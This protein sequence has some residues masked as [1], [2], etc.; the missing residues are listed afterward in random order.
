MNSSCKY[1]ISSEVISTF[2]FQK[3]KLEVENMVESQTSI[4]VHNFHFPGNT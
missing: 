3:R 4:I 1:T 2:D